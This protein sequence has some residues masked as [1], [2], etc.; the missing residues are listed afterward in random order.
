MWLI[1]QAYSLFVENR[2]LRKCCVAQ[3]KMC[4]FSGSGPSS[5]LWFIFRLF[6]FCV[7][8]YMSVHEH[9]H[10]GSIPGIF[11]SAL[12]IIFWDEDFYWTWS[13]RIYITHSIF[14]N[15]TPHWFE[16]PWQKHDISTTDLHQSF[17][18]PISKMTVCFY[19]LW[20]LDF[21][22]WKKPCK[23]PKCFPFETLYIFE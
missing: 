5:L 8:M 4:N 13:W 18:S 12:H 22:A 1:Y 6:Y 21:Q 10:T 15:R 16:L 3:E 14:G 17:L 11:F 23:L 9:G 7:Y 20:G 2:W 19:C